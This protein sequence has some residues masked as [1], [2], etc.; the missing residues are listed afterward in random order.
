MASVDYNI[1][2][3]GLDSCLK[4][5]LLLPECRQGLCCSNVLGHRFDPSHISLLSCELTDIAQSRLSTNERGGS[6]L[7]LAPGAESHRLEFLCGH[8]QTV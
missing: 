6:L 4:H 3:G 7:V 5:P 2:A 1:E 8:R